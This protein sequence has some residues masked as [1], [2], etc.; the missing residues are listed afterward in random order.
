MTFLPISI[1]VSKQQIL[2]V[3]GG[4]VALHKITLLKRFT[5]NFKVIAPRILEEVKEIEGV[6]IEER[7]Y[8][9]TD[10]KSHLLVY[11]TTNNHELNHQI[12][13]QGKKYGCLVNVADSAEYSDFVSPAIFKHGELTIAVGSNGKDVKAS[14]ALRNK[15]KRFLRG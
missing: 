8:V 7:N 3:G 5:S 1:N 11:A 4:K 9:E 15:I 12:S 2:I 14:I 10:L 6:E 13:D